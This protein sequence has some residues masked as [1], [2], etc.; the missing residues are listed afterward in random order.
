[1]VGKMLAEMQPFR[2]RLCMPISRNCSYLT[3]L[4]FAKQP[5]RE[6]VHVDRAK[7]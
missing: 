2:I 6:I 1:M 7:L 3:H 5:F 4:L